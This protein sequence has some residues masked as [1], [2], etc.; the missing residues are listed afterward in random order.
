M[1]PKNVRNS[2]QFPRT[3]PPQPQIRDSEAPKSHAKK[4][5][6]LVIENPASSDPE[7]MMFCDCFLLIGTPGAKG[8]S[9]TRLWE[10][11]YIFRLSH[12]NADALDKHPIAHCQSKRHEI[13]MKSSDCPLSELG[14]GSPHYTR[15]SPITGHEFVA[16][17]LATCGLRQYTCDIC[18]VIT[19]WYEFVRHCCFPKCEPLQCATRAY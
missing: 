14:T 10:K 5:L 8:C 9:T 6:R 2:V 11:I 17:A 13:L 1:G 4:H 12:K 3:K 15:K 19:T 16:P 7:L 18:K